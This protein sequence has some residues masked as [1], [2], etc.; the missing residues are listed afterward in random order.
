MID[1]AHCYSIIYQVTCEESNNGK[2]FQVDPLGVRQPQEMTIGIN[3]GKFESFAYDIRDQS[4]PR[5]FATVDSSS[6]GALRRFTPDIADWS[7]PW[8]MLHANGTIDYLLLEPTSS[9]YSNNGTFSWTNDYD[10][11][12]ENS[13]QYYRNTEGIDVSGNQLFVV[14]K[15]QKELFILDLD[16]MTYEV[17]STVSG[18]FDGQPDQMKRLINDDGHSPDN[19]LYFCEESGSKNGVHARDTNGW[20]FTILESIDWGGETSGLAFSPDGKH[21]YF[22]YQHKGIIFDVWR[23]DG[24]PFHGKTLSVKYHDIDLQ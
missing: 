7:D 10:L 2:I 16:A 5:F 13:A 4:N 24:L 19:L 8:N 1:V 17:H 3:G 22:S 23:D 14:S 21:M 9:E 11:A 18:L 20:Y 12:K 15:V 6:R